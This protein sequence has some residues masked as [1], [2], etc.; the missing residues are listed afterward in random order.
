MHRFNLNPEQTRG[1][2]LT[3][4][5]FEAKHAVQV[6]RL[7]AG[8]TVEILNGT[9][10]VIGARVVAVSRA[11]VELTVVARVQSPPLPYRL[12]LLQ[13]IPKGKTMDTIVHKAT[14]L[15]TSRVVPL[16][17]ER[18]EVHLDADRGES[19]LEKWRVVA[20]EAMKQCGCPWLPQIDPP[21]SLD[22]FLGKAWPF[23]LALV[24]SL[25]KDARHPREVMGD[26]LRNQARPPRQ[27]AIWIGPEGDFS[28]SEYA[29]IKAA[30]ALPVTL[31]PFVLR[32]D[33][34]AIASLATMHFELQ[35]MSRGGEYP[36]GR[37]LGA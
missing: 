32:C 26:F 29:K 19:K 10:E 8:D 23:D 21:C 17:T 7:R 4:T 33:T 31:G 2:A 3:L 13:A 22:Q 1:N 14:E 9:G 24:G 27:L 25:E 35:A 12:T 20:F 34:A 28:P 15:G 5:G 30:G 18:T 37:N 6:L 36:V 11:Q 16:F